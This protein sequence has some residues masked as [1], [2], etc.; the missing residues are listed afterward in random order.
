MVIS[1]FGIW[2][3]S[4]FTTESDE[5]TIIGRVQAVDWDD[6]GNVTDAVF[7]GTGEDYKIVDNAV[8]KE[9]FRLD[10]MLVKATGAVAEDSKGRK[11][12]T[13]E[14]YDVLKE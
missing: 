1:L 9:L 14:D 7:F 13:V 10:G 4:G 5:A 8:G 12:L 6:K 2:T 11:S 3:A